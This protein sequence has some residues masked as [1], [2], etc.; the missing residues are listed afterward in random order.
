MLTF[1]HHQSRG[2]RVCIHAYWL[3]E[4]V[5]VCVKGSVRLIERKEGVDVYVVE[6]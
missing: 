6:C 3:C 5:Y 4:C 1:R 2:R